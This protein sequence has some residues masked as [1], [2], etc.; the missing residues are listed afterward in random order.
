MTQATEEKTSKKIKV[1][2]EKAQFESDLIIIS[3]GGKSTKEA[4]Q[5]AIRYATK[6]IVYRKNIGAAQQLDAKLCLMESDYYKKLFRSNL[7]AFC[8]DFRVET[9]GNENQCFYHEKPVVYMSKEKGKSGWRIDPQLWKMRIR[10]MKKNYET[11]LQNVHFATFKIKKKE[12]EKTYEEKI[13]AFAKALADQATVYKN[14][15]EVW[16]AIESPWIKVIEYLANMPEI[17]E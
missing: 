2:V 8:G 11:F 7:S 3:V 5:R 4:I 14:G 6:E 13:I 15:K 12:T 16:Q 10:S 17:K 1:D 9:K